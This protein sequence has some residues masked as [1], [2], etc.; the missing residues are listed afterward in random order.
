MAFEEFEERFD[1]VESRALGDLS[2]LPVPLDVPR[3]LQLREMR[4]FEFRFD[5]RRLADAP[6]PQVRLVD[7]PPRFSRR[8]VTRRER[9][10]SASRIRSLPDADTMFAGTFADI[11]TMFNN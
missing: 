2:R 3:F 10:P 6:E 5:R 8:R 4:P 11:A 7:D 9:V 1:L